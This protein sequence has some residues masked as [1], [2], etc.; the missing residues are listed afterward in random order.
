MSSISGLAPEAIQARGGIPLRA[1]LMQKPVNFDWLQ[2]YMT[3]MVTSHFKWQDQ[4]QPIPIRATRPVS[5][6]SG[7]AT[8]M[9]M[10]SSIQD[11]LVQ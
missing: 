1:H 11:G 3:A 2:G 8:S 4:A 6:E 10:V 9:R 7:S 5:I